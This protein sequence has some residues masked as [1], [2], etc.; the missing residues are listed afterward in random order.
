MQGFFVSPA[1]PAAEFR[2]FLIDDAASVA[3]KVLARASLD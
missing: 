3:L 1:L 2:R